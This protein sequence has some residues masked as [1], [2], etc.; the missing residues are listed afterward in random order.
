MLKKKI[1]VV[2]DEADFLHMVRSRLEAASYEVVTALDG[3]QGLQAA[4]R[5]KP[6]LILLDVSMPVMNGF[7]ALRQLRNDSKTRNIPV[8]MLTAQAD[9]TAIMRSQDLKATDYFT[10]PFESEELLAFIQRYIG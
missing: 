9:S 8:I 5:E 3:E 10:K 6:D 4:L 2:D 1:L 7:E